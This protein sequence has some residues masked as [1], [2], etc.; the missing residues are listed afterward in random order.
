MPALLAAQGLRKRFAGKPGMGRDGWIAAVDGVDLTLAE[1]EIVALV[2]ESGSGKSTLAR[3]LLRLIEPDGGSIEF[4]GRDL[5]GLGRRELRTRRRELQMIFQ[6]SI[7]ALDPRVRVGE[8]LAEPL[9]C[10]RLA[11]EG[12]VDAEVHRLMARVGLAESL[13]DRFPHQLSGGERQRVGI[14]RALATRPRLLVADEPVAA[15]DV[16]LRAQILNLLLELCRD[17]GV[18][19]LLILHN[20]SLVDRLADRVLVMYRGKIVERGASDELMRRPLHPYTAEL[21]ASVPWPDPTRALST[22]PSVVAEYRRDEGFAEGCS[23]APRCPFAAERCRLEAP[24]LRKVQ[25]GRWAA[26]HFAG[27]LD[28][29]GNFLGPSS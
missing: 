18:T 1:G 22:P 4:A 26:C 25:D 23:F 14:A 3:C 17:D 29:V 8:T 11:P 21:L 6:D 5:L 20:L 12:S 28:H 27:A 2:G 24:N 19:L 10:L 15:L 9:R 7:G 13:R 16:S